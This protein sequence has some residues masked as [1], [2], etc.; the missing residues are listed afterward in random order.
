MLEGR[1]EGREGERKH[2]FH[3]HALQDTPHI[4]AFQKTCQTLFHPIY[5]PKGT[6]P[7]SHPACP[8]VCYEEAIQHMHRLTVQLRE[9]IK[10]ACGGITLLIASFAHSNITQL[11]VGLATFLYN[12]PSVIS[13]VVAIIMLVH[14]VCLFL[15]ILT[16]NAMTLVFSGNLHMSMASWVQPT[17]TCMLRELAHSELCLQTNSSDVL[18][19]HCQHSLSY[20]IQPISAH[21]HE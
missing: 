11:K 8:I 10:A 17:I 19:L 20:N 15:F 1:T 6:V 13:I 4:Q 14:R 16:A 21:L 9:L 12:P 2:A 5:I 7:T 18:G 3:H